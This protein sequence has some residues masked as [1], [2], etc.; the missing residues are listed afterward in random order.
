M[1][2]CFFLL[3]YVLDVYV[4]SFNLVKV[5][6]DFSVL[7]QLSI[8]ACRPFQPAQHTTFLIYYSSYSDSSCDLLFS[9]VSTVVSGF[10]FQFVGSGMSGY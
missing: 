6:C 7:L 3:S 4:D 8:C 10:P 2:I 1:L 9:T 5:N